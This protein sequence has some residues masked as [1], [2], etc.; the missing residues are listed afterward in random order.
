MDGFCQPQQVIR[1]LRI[2]I[3]NPPCK[4]SFYAESYNAESCFFMVFVQSGDFY[5]L[6]RAQK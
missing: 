1:V 4:I 3:C 6:Q 5:V 2:R